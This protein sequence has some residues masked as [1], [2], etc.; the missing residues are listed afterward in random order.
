MAGSDISWGADEPIEGNASKECNSESS[1]PFDVSIAGRDG[2]IAGSDD[3][4]DGKVTSGPRAG[5]VT[6]SG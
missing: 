2:S 3:S 1:K 6:S 4:T 5:W